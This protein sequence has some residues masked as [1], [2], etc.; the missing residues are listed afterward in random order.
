MFFPDADGSDPTHLTDNLAWDV[1]PAWSPH[2]K[3]IAFDSDRMR[4]F[5]IWVMDVPNNYHK[6]R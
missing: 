5:D 3:K 1:F 2:G 6:I 4:N